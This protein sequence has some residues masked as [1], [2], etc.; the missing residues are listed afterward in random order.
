M[1]ESLIFGRADLKLEN[2]TLK[3]SFLSS[4]ITSMIA[5]IVEIM[6]K[7]GINNKSESD[8]TSTKVK[9]VEMIF[10]RMKRIVITCIFSRPRKTK[11]KRKIVP[12]IA[13]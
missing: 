2:L 13:V 3:S 4:R 1:V 5:T 8:F 11:S 10:I 6:S 12:K 7:I 9:A